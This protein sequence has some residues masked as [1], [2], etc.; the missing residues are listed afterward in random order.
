MQTRARDSRRFEDAFVPTT[1]KNHVITRSRRPCCTDYPRRRRLLPDSP[2]RTSVY[3]HALSGRRSTRLF[4]SAV[5]HKVAIRAHQMI[6]EESK[7]LLTVHD[8]LLVLSPDKFVEETTVALRAAMEEVVL[9]GI[10]VPLVAEVNVAH[11]WGECK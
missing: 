4:K 8:E 11:A 3:G 2:A 1:Y 10:T 7:M 5:D 6:P 9:P